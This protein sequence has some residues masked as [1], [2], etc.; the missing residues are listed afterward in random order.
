VFD[1]Q[2]NRITKVDRSGAFVREIGKAGEGPGEFR[3]AMQFTAVRDGRIVVADLGHRSYQLFGPGGEFERMVTMGGDGGSIR[4]GDLAA[5]PNGDAVISGGGSTMI[6]M[7]EGPGAPPNEPETRPIDVV[8]LTGSQASTRVLAAGWQPP[9]TPPTQLEGGGVSFS[10]STGGPRTFEPA[11]L[12]GA[13]PDGGVAFSDSSGY[14]IKVVGPDGA[15]T[16]VLRRPFRPRP[17]TEAIREGEKARR[18]AELEAGE[19]PRM[20][21]MVAGPGGGGGQAL[22]AEQMR[23]IM[24]NQIE[25]MQF[26]EELPVIQRLRASWTGKLW[27]ERRGAQ[28]TGAGPIDVLTATGQYVGTFGAGVTEIPSSFGPDGLAAYIELDDFDVPSVIVRRLPPV[29]N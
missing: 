1:R 28:P 24:E 25:Q 17:V 2:G 14:V 7:R 18:L 16:R 15:S 26:F 23:A 10:M 8:S 29:L 13:L 20:R 6:A 3:M 4:M 11:L 5:H 27:V 19:G 12:V 22:G 21:I 9:R